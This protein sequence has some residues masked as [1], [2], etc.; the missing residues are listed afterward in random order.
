MFFVVSFTSK[1]LIRHTSSASR[2]A[3]LF[4]FEESRLPTTDLPTPGGPLMII[5]FV[6][7][8]PPVLRRIIDLTATYSP[9]IIPPFE[10]E[11]PAR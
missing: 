6:N 4:N 2:N 10:L 1:G 3:E 8:W 11:P 9:V 5:N 7:T